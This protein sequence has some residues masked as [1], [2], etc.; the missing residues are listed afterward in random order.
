MELADRYEFTVVIVPPAYR[1]GEYGAPSS[2]GLQE[3][4]SPLPRLRI[5]GPAYYL[6]PPA[7]FSDPVHLNSN[8]AATYT[9]A[10]AALFRQL[11]GGER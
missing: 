5:A 11:P 8:G 7:M 4:N 10:V 9:N 3:P 6:Y 1:L 2:A